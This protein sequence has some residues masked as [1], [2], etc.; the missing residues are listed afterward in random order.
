MFKNF[1]LNQK[2]KEI[3]VTKN[4]NNFLGLK[5][6][7]PSVNMSPGIQSPSV[8]FQGFRCPESKRLVSR[9]RSAPNSHISLY[10]VRLKNK[11]FSKETLKILV[12]KI[13]FQT[14]K[15]KSI[16]ST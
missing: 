6:L 13:L 11:K 16:F 5:V 12:K 2:K 8:Q 7:S 1:T 3:S 4:R 10:H 15:K 14:S 9:L